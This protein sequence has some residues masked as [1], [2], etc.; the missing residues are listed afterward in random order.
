LADRLI[1]WSFAAAA[2][3]ALAFL[4]VERRRAFPMLPLGL[5]RDRTFSGAKVVRR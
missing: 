1:L 2:V 4:A 5:F 3:L